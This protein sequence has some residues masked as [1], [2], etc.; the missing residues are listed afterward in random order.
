[1]CSTGPKDIFC[2]EW[3]IWL[4][5]VYINYLL[6][7]ESRFPFLTKLNFS[8]WSDIR[9]QSTGSSKLQLSIK[10]CIPKSLQNSQ[11]VSPRVEFTVERTTLQMTSPGGT[12]WTLWEIRDVVTE[13]I[14]HVT[15]NHV[16]PTKTFRGQLHLTHCDNPR[17]TL[18]TAPRQTEDKT[19]AQ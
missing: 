19:L 6:L 2:S 17:A 7:I 9:Q 13:A 15:E 14:D 8:K 3:S 11:Y 4:A 16:R 12:S 1:M 5:C 18:F 10:P